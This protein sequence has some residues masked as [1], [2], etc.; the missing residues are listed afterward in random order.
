MYRQATGNYRFFNKFILNFPKIEKTRAINSNPSNGV[1]T[2]IF[3]NRCP[4]M[5]QIRSL[6]YIGQNNNARK[7]I[8]EYKR[9]KTRLKYLC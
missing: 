2:L 4:G 6:P 7:M 1:S 8:R 5:Y 3:I 9:I